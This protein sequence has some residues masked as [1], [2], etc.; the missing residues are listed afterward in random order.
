MPSNKHSNKAQD[1]SESKEF[2]YDSNEEPRKT[3][4]KKTKQQTH[5]YQ[6][7]IYYRNYYN[8]GHYIKE[9]KLQ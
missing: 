8:E 4:K 7:G 9:Y 1:E 6:W 2:D 5:I 3:R